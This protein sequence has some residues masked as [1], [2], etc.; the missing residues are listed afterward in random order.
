MQGVTTMTA[1]LDSLQRTVA[2]FGAMFFTTAIVLFS[3]PTVP[4]A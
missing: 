3:T 1:R 4:L 2:I